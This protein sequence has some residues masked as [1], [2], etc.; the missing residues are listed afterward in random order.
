[1]Q[2]DFISIESS[3]PLQGTVPLSG[4]KNAVLVIMTSL[5]LT[6]GKNRLS[7]V[8][9]SEDVLHMIRLLQSLGAE[10]VYNAQTK[11]LEVDTTHISSAE[12]GADIMRRMRAS[13]LAF[14]PLLARFGDAR[15]ALPGGCGL[16]ERPI[17]YHMNSFRKMGVTFSQTG[18]VLSGKVKTLQAVDHILA[19]PSVGATENIIMAAALTPGTT[20]IINAAIE[21]EVLDLIDVL[22]K[23]GARISLVPPASIIIE[24]VSSLAPIEHH[25]MADRLEA[26]TLLI[27]AAITGGE[28]SLPDAPASSMIVFLSLLE[29]MGHTITIDPSGTGIRLKAT[30]SPVAVSFKT[31]PYPGFPTDLQAPMMAALCLASGTSVIHET[32]FENRMMHIRELQKMGAQISLSG[33]TATVTGVDSLYGAAVIASDIRAGGKQD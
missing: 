15:M 3:P 7:N 17:D 4:A 1:M 6:R 27:A 25:V 5:I 33:Q 23:M 26:G 19:Y 14:G 24:G 10:V 21:P 12:I 29:Q 22:I 31:M 11:V 16:G 9:T 18:D 28:I 13:I 30:K 20:R 2:T 8:P 32:V